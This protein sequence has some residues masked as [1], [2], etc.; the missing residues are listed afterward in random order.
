M[1]FHVSL[2]FSMVV[3]GV[4]LDGGEMAGGRHVSGVLFSMVMRNVVLV[5]KEEDMAKLGRNDMM[6][7]QWW[8]CNVTLKDKKHKKLHTK[9]RGGSGKDI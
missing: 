8:M 7:R 9:C 6:V 4:V 2:L 1:G 3:R 5:V